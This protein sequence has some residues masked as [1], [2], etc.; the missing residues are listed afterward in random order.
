MSKR[1]TEE[2]RNSSDKPATPTDK[3]LSEQQKE[4]EEQKQFEEWKA[5]AQKVKLSKNDEATL[6]LAT[7]ALINAALND[8][9]KSL[10]V[11]H[12]LYNRNYKFNGVSVLEKN[13]IELSEVRTKK[14]TVAKY[15]MKAMKNKLE[16]TFSHYYMGCDITISYKNK[17][18]IFD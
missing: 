5:F 4:L 7:K 13:N 18:K 15:N 14:K 8:V 16:Y 9:A 17:L 10:S 12:G 11:L 1:T 3:A 6:D 2:Q